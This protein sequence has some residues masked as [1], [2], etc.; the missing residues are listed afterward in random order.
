[1]LK[2]LRNSILNEKEAIRIPKSVQASIPIEKIYDDGIWK[3]NNNYSRTWLF[4]DINFA[5]ASEDDKRAIL[6]Q[7]CSF[8]NS[9]PTDATIKITINNRKL[10]LKEFRHKLMLTSKKDNLDDYRAEYN[11]MLQEKAAATQNMTQEKYITVAINKKTIEEARAAFIRIEA[12]LISNLSRLSSNVTAMG[13]IERLKLLHDFFRPNDEPDINIDLKQIMR[14]GHNFKDYICS[15]SIMFKSDYFE[16][17][18][19]V[20]SRSST[21]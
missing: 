3:V 19:K 2:T 4:T 17:D 15:D 7:Y 12:D 1:M 11:R 20:G 21:E 14:H 6:L 9:L 16:I 8:L 18:E 5:V 13:N 10:N